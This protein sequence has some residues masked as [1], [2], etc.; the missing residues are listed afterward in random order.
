[1]LKAYYSKKEDI[2]DEYVG[3]YKQESD[4]RWKLQAEGVEDI[5]GLKSALDK[6]RDDRKAAKAALKELS[7]KIGDVDIEAALVALGEK[8]KGD[9]KKMSPEAYEQAVT[10]EVDK[11]VSKMRADL[12]TD[13][14]AWK[15][16]A[17][18]LGGKLHAALVDTGLS[19]A[20][21]AAGV[22]AEAASDAMRRGREVFGLSDEGEVI[23]KDKKGDILYGSDGR[24]SL[25]PE[26]FMKGLRDTA[27]HLFGKNT[28]GGAGQQQRSGGAGQQN[29]KLMGAA[30]MR[31]AHQSAS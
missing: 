29:G 17:E 30:L 7:D 24:T 11:R 26:E 12:E 28:G 20:A 25:T 16:K 15:G 5:T 19:A 14:D 21:T 27:S 4:G 1:M 22:T 18:G 8:Q 2:P 10:A 3:L 6:E 13:R 31:D 23:A 9:L